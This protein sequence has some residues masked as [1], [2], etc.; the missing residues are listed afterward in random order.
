MV[1]PKKSEALSSE[2]FTELIE[3]FSYI[4]NPVLLIL[5][6][7]QAI[8]LSVSPL[9]ALMEKP[10]VH[11]IITTHISV[12]SNSIVST[13]H[14]SLN[15]G[16]HI[17]SLLP[18]PF[19]Q[20]MQRI[21][22][23]IVRNYELSPMNHEQ[24]ILEEIEDLAC[25]NSEVLTLFCA[26]IECI[27]EKCDDVHIGLNTFFD[28]VVRRTNRRLEKQMLNSESKPETRTTV[29]VSSKES[30]REEGGNSVQVSEGTDQPV[31]S[32]E[33]MDRESNF[34]T[35]E[36]LQDTPNPAVLV[37]TQEIIH[38][39]LHNQVEYFFLSCIST[40]NAAPIHNM[41]LN[42]LEGR[43]KSLAGIEN[44]L[45]VLAMKCNILVKYPCPVVSGPSNFRTVPKN[46]DDYYVMPEVISE[47]FYMSLNKKDKAIACSMVN[48][49]LNEILSRVDDVPTSQETTQQ[50]ETS[51]SH[52]YDYLSLH[53]I[54][55]KQIL[56]L[57]LK[58]EW[59]LFGSDVI[60]SV[61]RQYI[62]DKV[63]VSGSYEI[64]EL[65]DNII[66]S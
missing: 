57:C 45:Q 48:Y 30:S 7:F 37:F 13:A 12:A 3:Y 41:V 53:V 60:E 49:T 4:H 25:G 46:I 59:S 38:S 18:I 43:I 26:A 44:N 56:L 32:V 39:L 8:P 22:Y 42:S 10:N 40:L 19:L 15:R 61:T 33:I 17:H 63:S 52:S 14:K 55:L 51:D 27:M 58:G 23:F 16:C 24:E 11:I 1:L 28:T 66:T 6:H 65:L 9:K 29:T 31:E 64:M 35:D 34:K 20:S 2:S 47:A 62:A 36:E 5:H 50:E 54:G 21:I